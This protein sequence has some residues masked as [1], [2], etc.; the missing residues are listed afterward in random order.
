M[1]WLVGLV[2][3]FLCGWAMCRSFAES[4]RYLN[5]QLHEGNWRRT[6]VTGSVVEWERELES[7]DFSGPTNHQH[8]AI[9]CEVD[10][11]TNHI[12]HCWCGATR[13]GV[14]GAWL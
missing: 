13:H 3:G 5:P 7:G 10:N 6:K 9:H 2:A 4:A 8:F 12:D 14:F 1:G 11:R